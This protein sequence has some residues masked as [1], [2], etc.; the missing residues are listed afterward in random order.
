MEKPKEREVIGSKKGKAGGGMGIGQLI[1][2][3]K[4]TQR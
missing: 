2:P 3:V 4:G 1:V